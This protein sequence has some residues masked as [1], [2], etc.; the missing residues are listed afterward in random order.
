LF[1]SFSVWLNAMLGVKDETPTH[2]V[3]I[4]GIPRMSQTDFLGRLEL[5]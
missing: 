3:T 2:L 5:I 4:G 1:D